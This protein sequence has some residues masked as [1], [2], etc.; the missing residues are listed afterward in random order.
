[1]CANIENLTNS[2]G[3]GKMISITKLRKYQGL[4]NLSDEEAN[5][6]IKSL[7][8]LSLLTLKIFKNDNNK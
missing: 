8:K 2:E 5:Q 1:M 4:E 7:Y 3:N 6:I